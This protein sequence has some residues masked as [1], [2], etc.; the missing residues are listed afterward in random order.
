MLLREQPETKCMR[1]KPAWLI[2]LLAL[3]AAIN[4][5]ASAATFSMTFEVT[6]F[7]SFTG[8]LPPTDP[9]FGTIVWEAPGIH[10][11]VQSIDS[12]DMSLAGHTY[13][14]SEIGYLNNFGTSMIG[15]L[16]EGV[17]MMLGSTHDFWISWNPN[18]LAP[19]DF[20]YTAARNPGMW[21]AQGFPPG[22]FP[23]FSITEVP[24][25]S[26][27]LLI[28]LALLSIGALHR[29]RQIGNRLA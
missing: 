18:T 27:I 13:S 26:S 24:E 16:S 6:G 1:R 19:S 21:S 20:A 4:V 5:T 23:I 12:I 9:V 7:Q 17:D 2:V 29:R 8:N 15:G 11:P 22:S 10:D 25:P 3:F 14:V 28:G